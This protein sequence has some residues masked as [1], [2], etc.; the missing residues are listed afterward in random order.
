MYP[1]RGIK[2]FRLSHRKRSSEFA[3]PTKSD[4]AQAST[5]SSRSYQRESGSGSGSDSVVD[6]DTVEH[7]LF[8][9]RYSPSAM[10]RKEIKRSNMTKSLEHTSSGGKTNLMIAFLFYTINNLKIKFPVKILLPVFFFISYFLLLRKGM[11]LLLL[12]LS[13]SIH[14]AHSTPSIPRKSKLFNFKQNISLQ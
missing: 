14:S 7:R 9:E 11:L 13:H 6:S 1:V 12:L 8:N 4:L 2:S 3:K 10:V 5:S